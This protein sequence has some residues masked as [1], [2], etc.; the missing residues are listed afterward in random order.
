MF[1]EVY[2]YDNELIYFGRQE[3]KIEIAK[4]GLINGIN[5]ETIVLMTGLDKAMILDLQRKLPGIKV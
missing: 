4:T 3:E 5:I 2:S 1:A